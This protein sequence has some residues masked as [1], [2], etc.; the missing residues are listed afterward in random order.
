[1]KRLHPLLVAAA[2]VF[3]AATAHAEQ[4]LRYSVTTA[5]SM[6]VTGNTLGLSGGTGTN[7]PGTNGSISTFITSDTV[8]ADG[9][10]PGGTTSDWRSNESEAFLDIPIGAV[11]LYA[12]LI[13]GGSW[14]A[15]SEDVSA[16]RNDA[17]TLTT[18]EGSAAVSPDPDTASDIDLISGSGFAVRYYTRS[19]N[20]TDQVRAAGR[21]FYGVSGVPGTQD[22][23]ITELNAA[24]WSLAVV[25]HDSNEPGRNL[26][27]FLGADWVDEDSTLDTVATGF[28]SPP[29]GDV[30]GRIFVTAIEGDAHFAGD[31]LLVGEEGSLVVVE[32]PFNPPA[33]FFG[34]QL[35]DGDGQRDTRGT[36]GDRNQDPIARANMAG[37]RQGW[38]ITAAPVSS[39]AGHLVNGQTS[40]VLR[41]QTTGDSFVVSMVGFEIDVNSPAFDTEA[42][43]QVLPDVVSV[44]DDVT[45]ETTIANTGSA[46][47]DDVVF[48]LE[49]PDE[50]SL[51]TD[52]I[53]VN[54]DVV[55][56]DR[57]ELAE[58]VALGA[59]P[60]GASVT[61]VV[62]VTVESLVAGTPIRVAPV[63]SYQWRTCPG[64]PPVSADAYSVPGVLETGSIQVS[65]SAEP[66]AGELLAPYDLVT[67]RI[68][69]DNS[70]TIPTDELFAA[71]SPP[72]GAV[73]IPGTTFINDLAVA[74]GAAFPLVGGLSLGS[75][76]V[77]ASV[78]V[79]T[80]FEVAPL[81][82]A[83]LTFAAEVAGSDVELTHGID[84]D[85][86]GDGW[87]NT[88]EDLD[89]DG[90]LFDDDTDRDGDP[91]F[92]DPDDDGDG[93]P[94][95]DDNCPLTPNADQADSDDDGVGDA[96]TGD[97]DG[98][99]VPDEDDNCPDTPNPDQTDTDGEGEGDAC[100]IDDDGDGVPD[101]DDNCPR[102]ANP[103]QADID[104]DGEGDACDED[105]DGDG[106]DN[107]DE[108]LHGTDPLD[109]DTDDGGVWD[110]EEVGRRTDPLDPSD[111]FP[112]DFGDMGVDEG[113]ARS[114]S[115]AGCCATSQEPAPA[116]PAFLVAIALVGLRRRRR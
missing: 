72:A 9:A 34:S 78:V 108:D 61:V 92:A 19:A 84:D 24:G 16:N 68:A 13:W 70:G 86:D 35:N 23:A 73:Y 116:L 87:S 94:T 67:Y 6:A 21:G 42:A 69:V 113:D 95:R 12:E 41:A 114:T 31:A 107:D 100:D 80:S 28:C 76:A 115:A 85:V 65:A 74:D 98:D 62:E 33:N 50:V 103:D 32:G 2:T 40:A 25:Y 48:R 51:I 63:W 11:V 14:A 99:G 60:V 38:D 111:D 43:T 81:A 71:A 17:V 66:A 39:A 101:G 7:A 57:T 105:A 29:T 82:S 5:G 3:F 53:L 10:F 89:G 112:S 109:P 49:L 47:A 45:V 96:C 55:D 1:M 110:G 77:G 93:V 20:V 52:T 90:E 83:E 18:R 56:V 75:V 64:A 79:E 37:G 54:E 106:L 4:T 22:A 30:D 26:S 102:D 36:F 27:L 97:R 91:N 44:G 58:G 15:G 46:D 8:S 88:A 104:G 59:I